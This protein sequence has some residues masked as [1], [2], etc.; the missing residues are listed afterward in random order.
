MLL[1]YDGFCCSSLFQVS[2]EC[3][4][5]AH[6]GKGTISARDLETGK[7]RQRLLHSVLPPVGPWVRQVREYPSV[8]NLRR[9]P[10]TV[11]ML[12]QSRQ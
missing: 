12:A 3:L 9:H 8:Q 11:P 6:S 7:A 10:K 5:L 1:A 2:R 4:S